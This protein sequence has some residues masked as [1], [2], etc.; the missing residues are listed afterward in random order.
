LGDKAISDDI[1]CGLGPRLLSGPGVVD[2][3]L[4]C[5]VELPSSYTELNAVFDVYDVTLS[6]HINYRELVKTVDRQVC[7]VSLITGCHV[8][9]YC[10]DCIYA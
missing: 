9:V 5:A 1:L 4:S 7:R 10:V 8:D 2:V 3:K 6:G